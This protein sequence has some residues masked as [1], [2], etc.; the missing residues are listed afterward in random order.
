MRNRIACI[1]TFILFGLLLVPQATLAQ[2][3]S[4]STSYVD[5]TGFEMVVIITYGGGEFVGYIVKEDDREVT[6]R[7]TDRGDVTIPKYEIKEIKK[8]KSTDLDAQGQ[9]V[10]DQI[11][12]TRYFITTN[13]LPIKKGEN[14]VLLNWW[15]PEAHWAVDDNFNVG[16]MTT[17]VGIPLI[18][19]A[20]YSFR[21]DENVHFSVGSLF[22]WGSFAA[23][24]AGGVLPFAAV[25]FGDRKTN[26]NVI[27]GY[28]QVF[29]DGDR[30][31]TS[32]F[33]IGGMTPISKKSSFVFDSFILPEANSVVLLPGVRF[34]SRDNNAF[35]FGFAG[36]V[37]DGEAV[38]VPIPLFGAFFKF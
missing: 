27:G 15:G 13:A 17:W 18:L 2:E 25:T 26:F 23:P 7:T 10:R 29:V 3:A 8:I 34:Q 22:G 35:Q 36:I 28:A 38:P 21:I 32:L 30:G 6:I 4:D 31:G 11:F 20:K 9:F 12:A 37:A 24:D 5:S 19:N 16:V 14:Y 1:F 33:S